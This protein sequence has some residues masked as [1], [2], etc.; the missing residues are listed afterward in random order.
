MLSKL[1]MQDSSLRCNALEDPSKA[2]RESLGECTLIMFHP[3]QTKFF[4]NV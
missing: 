4:E 3:P 1:A 2:H